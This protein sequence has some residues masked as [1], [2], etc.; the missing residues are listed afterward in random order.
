MRK[1]VE[2][3]QREL[4]DVAKV[5]RGALHAWENGGSPGLDNFERVLAVF[6]YRLAIEKIPKK[7]GGE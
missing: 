6:G 5:S 3:S 4:A 7:E 2:L 1:E